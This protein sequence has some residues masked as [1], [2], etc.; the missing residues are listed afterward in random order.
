MPGQPDVESAVVGG[1]VIGLAIAAT[2]ARRGQETM[3]FER[4]ALLGQE[5]T[6]RSSEVIHAGLYYPPSFLKATA[7]VEGRRRIYEFCSEN[8]I[9]AKRIGKLIVATTDSELP[10]L[11]NIE[12]NAAA[13][14][15]MDLVKLDRA[16]VRAFE[17]ELECVAA[18]LS[19][20]TGIIDSHALV[21]ALEGHLTSHGGSIVTATEL[22]DVRV[23]QNG[24]FELRLNSRGGIAV[25]TARNLLV[26][27]GLG[28]AALRN[29]LPRK[30]HYTPPNVF[31]CKGHYYVLKGRAPFRHLV[32][33]VPVAGGLGTHLTL[34]L[35]GCARFGPDVEWIDHI[36]YRFA[37]DG[38][39]RMSEFEGAIRRYWPG[40]PPDAL[41]E[42]Y[43]GIRPKI[44]RKGD[45]P[46]D[47]A[48]HGPG[49]HGIDRMV[50]VYG[51]ESPGLT[52]CLALA[53]HCVD[54]LV[55][56]SVA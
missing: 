11:N 41:A 50:A 52:S 56:E 54:C 8:G 46:A 21:Q 17:P 16:Q 53:D 40:L 3:L 1:G 36:D 28:M 25:L 20:S 38:G 31:Y 2:C 22:L 33:P 49:A 7:C 42:G 18:V 39:S 47:F 44:S 48:V 9:A 55:S 45:P 26:S 10:A 14:G 29:V 12:R 5:I 6:A 15:V 35:Q 43:T 23:T 24:L 34:D 37:E 19:P 27:A 30:R 51:I 4:N 13:S 32:Y